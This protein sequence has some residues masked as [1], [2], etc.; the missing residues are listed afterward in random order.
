MWDTF[1]RVVIFTAFLLATVA[2]CSG[3]ATLSGYGSDLVTD[4]ADNCRH[5]LKRAS[6]KQNGDKTET[7][8]ECMG[9]GI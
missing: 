4:M 5:G 3:C 6:V 9:Y 7:V 8:V 2:L 1:W